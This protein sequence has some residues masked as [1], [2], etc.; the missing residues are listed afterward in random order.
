MPGPVAAPTCPA[1]ALPLRRRQFAAIVA[2]AWAAGQEPAHGIPSAQPPGRA[3]FPTV[4]LVNQRGEPVRFY[5]DL[6]RGDHT[7]AINF[8][9]AQCA[10][11]CPTTT[12]NIARVQSLLGDRLG[13][14]VRIAS[15]SIDPRRDTP[16][17]LKAYAEQFGARPGWDFLTGQ[18]RGIDR[19]RRHLGVYERDPA[20]DRDKTQHTGMLVY[21][22]Q[23]RGRWSRVSV[24][25]D[26][27]RIADSITRWT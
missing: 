17:I 8:M 5:D 19:I 14:Q 22:N 24:L 25:A 11:I 16:A 1:R 6:V 13:R 3:D 18:P 7:I 10:D 12:A 20:R 4:V 23:A 9:Y 26:P 2:V 21:G 27:Q 15:I